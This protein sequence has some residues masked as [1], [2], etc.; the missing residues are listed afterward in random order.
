MTI[1]VYIYTAGNV[2]VY[3]G[4]HMYGRTY[5]AYLRTS[6]YNVL[7][8]RILYHTRASVCPM[9]VTVQWEL[10]FVC[11]F[12]C[13][14]SHFLSILFGE[15]FFNLLTIGARKKVDLVI[16]PFTVLDPTPSFIMVVSSG[17]V[18]S[19]HDRSC[20]DERGSACHMLDNHTLVAT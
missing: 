3:W 20:Y 18:T 1:R 14:Q 6:E 10:G 5:D 15:R 8:L 16:S 2:S 7:L 9:Y 11:F 13:Q 19:R 12:P 4:G 17:R